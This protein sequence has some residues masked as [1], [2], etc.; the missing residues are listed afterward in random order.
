MEIH[1]RIIEIKEQIMAIEHHNDAVNDVILMHDWEPKNAQD[2]E[3][4]RRCC[5]EM[6]DILHRARWAVMWELC[7]LY[8]AEEEASSNAD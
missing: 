4:M 2:W 5:G 6:L 1:D 8:K 7:D 3:A